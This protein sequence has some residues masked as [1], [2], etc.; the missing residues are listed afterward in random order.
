MEENI[1]KLILHGVEDT[2]NPEY[3]AFITWRKE[4]I[5]SIKD[6][7]VKDKIFYKNGTITRRFFES[8]AKFVTK[9]YGAKYCNLFGLE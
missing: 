2:L 6:R 8:N 9:R 3:Q 1:N 7:L 5:K 4:N